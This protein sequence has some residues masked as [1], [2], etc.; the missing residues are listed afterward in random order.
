VITAFIGMYGVATGMEGFMDTKLNPLFRM[1]CIGGG[2][3]LIVPGILTDVIGI[4]AV[5]VVTFLQK[6]AVKK[7]AA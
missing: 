2:L 7:A 5:A 1:I 6:R 3:L 4:S